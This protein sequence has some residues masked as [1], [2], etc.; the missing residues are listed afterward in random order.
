M[1]PCFFDVADISEVR[2]YEGTKVQ[3]YPYFFVS[4]LQLGNNN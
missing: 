1:I 4:Q 3:D 2:G